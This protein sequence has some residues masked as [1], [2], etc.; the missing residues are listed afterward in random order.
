MQNQCISSK[1][2]LEAKKIMPVEKKFVV[3]S[4]KTMIPLHRVY[5]LIMEGYKII[6]FALLTFCYIMLYPSIPMQFGGGHSA[7]VRLV[8]ESETIPHKEPSLFYLY[9]EKSVLETN[10]LLITM[11][12]DLVHLSKEM[13]YV[14]SR[15]NSV[16]GIEAKAVH[17]IIFE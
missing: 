10:K 3:L 5:F 16:I 2:A 8:I 4:M 15:T 6:V 12:V 11:S 17:A 13:Y 1:K 14:R 9:D 7:R